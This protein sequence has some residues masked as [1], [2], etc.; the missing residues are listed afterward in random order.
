MVL[1][2]FNFMPSRWNQFR[3]TM[4]NMWVSLNY[5]ITNK[6]NSLHKGTAHSK[7][8]EMFLFRSKKFSSGLMRCEALALFLATS[9]ISLF[10]S[11]SHQEREMERYRRERERVRGRGTGREG[12]GRREMERERGERGRRDGEREMEREQ[13]LRTTLDH[14]SSSEVHAAH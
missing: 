14:Y 2:S 12:E 3:L 6:N 1:H 4:V 7:N 13:V 11:P 10:L 9:L 8:E 5:L